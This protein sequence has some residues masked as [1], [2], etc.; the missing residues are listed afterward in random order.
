MLV[1]AHAPQGGPRE[2]AI[3]PVD[4]GEPMRLEVQAPRARAVARRGEGLAEERLIRRA[5]FQG[6]RGLCRR[7]LPLRGGHRGG[8][9]SPANA[10]AAELPRTII[11]VAVKT[12]GPFGASTAPD[13]GLASVG[14][15]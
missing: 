15:A 5:E 11:I 4:E 7:G 12:N 14:L 8:I 1:P 2:K 10:G 13:S 6:E 3:E 9:P